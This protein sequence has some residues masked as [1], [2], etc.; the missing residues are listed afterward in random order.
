[1]IEKKK[2]VA[3]AG[4]DNVFHEPAKLKEYS[5]D[6]SFVDKIKPE[7]IV[8]VKNAEEVQALVK[9]ANE[10]KTPLVPI[11]SGSP[12]FRG[13]TVP[14]MGGSIIVDLSGMKKIV[15]VDREN[16][17][18]LIEPGVTFSELISAAEKKGIRLNMPLA[19]RG[20]KSVVGSMLERE[21]VIMPKYHWDISDPIACAEV[22][23]GT[24]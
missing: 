14:S 12:H 5:G 11:S 17:D 15:R 19:P 4:A 10:T 1:M 7:C 3:I 22:I 16:R 6:M 2:L 13:D 24:G 8:R 23:F 18:V 9:L 20:S 21:P